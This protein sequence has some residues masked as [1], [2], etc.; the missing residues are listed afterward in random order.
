MI[1]ADKALQAVTI[2]MLHVV[3]SEG[4]VKVDVRLHYFLSAPKTLKEL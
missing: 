2:D 1:L 3:V 4:N